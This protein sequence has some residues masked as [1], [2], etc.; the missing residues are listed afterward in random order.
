MH[1][2]PMYNELN[3]ALIEIKYGLIKTNAQQFLYFIKLADYSIFGI[4]KTKT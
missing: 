4:N 3:Y 2:A 1:I